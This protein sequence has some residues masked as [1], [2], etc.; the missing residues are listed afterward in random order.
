M[1][2]NTGTS[3]ATHKGASATAGANGAQPKT[4]A[5]H[6]EK[7]EQKVPAA[8]NGKHSKVEGGESPHKINTINKHEK[9]L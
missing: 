5:I 6:K 7:E 8:H 9:E 2:K 3:A 4:K 1:V